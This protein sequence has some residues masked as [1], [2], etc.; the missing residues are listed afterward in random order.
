M[1]ELITRSAT[2]IERKVTGSTAG[3]LLGAAIVAAVM[4]WL[5]ESAAD[6]EG[7]VGRIVEWAVGVGFVGVTTFVGGYITRSKAGGP[8]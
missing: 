8:Q 7:E 4:S 1:A 5:P 2:D 6:I 3:G